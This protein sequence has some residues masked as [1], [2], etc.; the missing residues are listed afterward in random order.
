MT[1]VIEELSQGHNDSCD[2]GV[3]TWPPICLRIYIA[4]KRIPVAQ[5]IM[6]V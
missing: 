2:I 3:V 4:A 1:A 5:N 6:Y